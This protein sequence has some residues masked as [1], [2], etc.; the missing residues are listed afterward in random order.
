MLVL[1]CLQTVP[2]ADFEAVYELWDDYTCGATARSIFTPVTRY[3]KYVIS[4]LHW[5]QERS[6][7]RLP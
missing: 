5:P 1:L 2:R 7:G 3:S 4:I 6:G